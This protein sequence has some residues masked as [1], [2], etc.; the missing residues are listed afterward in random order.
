MIVHI[1]VQVLHVQGQGCM[2]AYVAEVATRTK[3]GTGSMQYCCK[4]ESGHK[5]ADQKASE[6]DVCR[7]DL[8][9]KKEGGLSRDEPN[10]PEKHG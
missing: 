1:H 4:D 2:G 7:D 5:C 6:L 8:P 9:S 10:G 3:F